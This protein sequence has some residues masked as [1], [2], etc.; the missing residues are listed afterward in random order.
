MQRIFG[1]CKSCNSQNGEPLIKISSTP[2]AQELHTGAAVNL[3]CKAWQTDDLAMGY[4]PYKIYWYDPQDKRVG[5]RCQ[6]ASPAAKEMSC[7]LMVDPLTK[8]NV[9]PTRVKQSIVNINAA[10]KD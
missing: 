5:E 3:T 6:A 9:V 4:R 2:S 10:T 1:H 8:K 7:S